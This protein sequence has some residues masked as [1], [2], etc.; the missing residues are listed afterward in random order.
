MH[1]G[2][3]LYQS[4]LENLNTSSV[5][6]AIFFIIL[7]IHSLIKPK[8]TMTIN[9]ENTS[10][11][12]TNANLLSESPTITKEAFVMGADA[13]SDENSVDIT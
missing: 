7:S 1:N 3:L 5:D 2:Y 8:Q 6:I 13:D 9:H 12:K 10:M 11:S 4:N